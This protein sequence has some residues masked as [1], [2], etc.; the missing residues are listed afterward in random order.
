VCL[1]ASC[2]GAVGQDPA[3][4]GTPQD[5][6]VGCD[7]SLTYANFGQAFFAA[8]CNSCHGFTQAAA[9]GEP[10]TLSGVVLEDFMP[11]GGGNLT[12]SDRQE[13]ADWLACG[14]P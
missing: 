8:H 3:D 1:L 13:F 10:A 7:S 5:T 11:P 2:G 6:G 4:S 9:Q 12:P 14:A